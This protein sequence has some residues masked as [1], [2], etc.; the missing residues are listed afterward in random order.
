[1]PVTYSLLALF[2]LASCSSNSKTD[3]ATTEKNVQGNQYTIVC[4]NEMQ[5]CFQRCQDLCPKGYVVV[6]RVRGVRVGTQTDYTVI[7]RCK[8]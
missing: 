3:S 8:R 7:I 1:M 2:L 5:D 6:N 4:R